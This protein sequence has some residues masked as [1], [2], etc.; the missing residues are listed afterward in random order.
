MPCGKFGTL[1]S[2][3]L[4]KLIANY[5]LFLEILIGCI[6]LLSGRIPIYWIFR[7]S[8]WTITSYNKSQFHTNVSELSINM[9]SL[10][11]NKST[12]EFTD[13][14]FQVCTIYMGAKKWRQI[15]DFWISFHTTTIKS[16]IL[17][18]LPCSTSCSNSKILVHHRNNFVSF[19]IWILLCCKEI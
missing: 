9:I 8:F 14:G 15:L 17:I 7:L 2:V 12:C 18:H 10:I 11:R 4:R 13:H 1:F 19:N 3:F 6:A 16:Q 5:L